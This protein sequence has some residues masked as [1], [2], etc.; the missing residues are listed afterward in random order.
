MNRRTLLLLAAL[1]APTAFAGEDA[2]VAKFYEVKTD[3]PKT[4]KNGEQGKLSIAIDAKPGA[5]I[6]DDAP[7]RIELSGSGVKLRKTK[8]T[9]ADAVGK[10][11]EGK[12][13]AAPRFEVP[14]TAIAAGK[15]QLDA[16]MTF[17]VCT[18]KVCSRQQKNVTIPL[19]ID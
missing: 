15:G 13:S 17:F 5:H 9:R 16:K 7:V 6:S 11:V 3:A 1:A 8:L 18:D 4:L 19:E 2:D 10:K 14:F 12:E